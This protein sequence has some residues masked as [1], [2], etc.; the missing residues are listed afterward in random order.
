MLSQSQQQQQPQQQQPY[1]DQSALITSLAQGAIRTEQHGNQIVHVRGDSDSDLEALFSVLHNMDTSR[2]PSSSY[3]NRKLPA[4]FFRPPDHKSSSA[5]GRSVSSPA[6]LHHPMPGAGAPGSMASGQSQ[7]QQQQQQQQHSFKASNSDASST[8]ADEFNSGQ[9]MQC[10]NWETASKNCPRYF[11]KYVMQVNRM[12]QLPVVAQYSFATFTV[13][14]DC[15]LTIRR[16]AFTDFQS[17]DLP[18][19][20]PSSVFNLSSFTIISFGYLR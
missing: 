16:I 18:N 15:R 13:G 1:V 2:P 11:L 9:S 4:S 20:L 5:H 7:Q 8:F 3:K 6:Q 19:F 12:I 17:F 10:R 14:R